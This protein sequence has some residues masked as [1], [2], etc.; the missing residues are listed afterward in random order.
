[1]TTVYGQVLGVRTVIWHFSVHCWIVHIIARSSVGQQTSQNTVSQYL[2][3]LADRYSNSWNIWYTHITIYHN[4]WNAVHRH[5]NISSSSSCLKLLVR[6]HPSI[7]I[8]ETCGWREF[9]PRALIGTRQDAQLFS[10]VKSYRWYSPKY[11]STVC[12]RAMASS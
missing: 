12:N 8:P 9:R 6:S 11:S 4:T 1:M 2:R 7:T 5:H 3:H 10:V